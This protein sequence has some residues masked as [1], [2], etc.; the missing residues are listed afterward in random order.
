MVR[1]LR[2]SGTSRCIALPSSGNCPA[3]KSSKSCRST[4]TGSSGGGSP[5][6]F[7]AARGSMSARPAIS[8]SWMGRSN[9]GKKLAM[10]PNELAKSNPLLDFSVLPRFSEIAPEHVAP[11]I[12]ALIGEARATIEQVASVAA[13]PTWESFVQP[14]A[15]VEDRLERAWGQVS[16][17]NAVVNTPSLR[18][19]Y[20]AALPKV[21]A[22]HNELAQDE[23]LFSGYHALARVPEAAAFDGGQRKLID[24][25]LRDFR[26]S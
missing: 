1:R 7:I 9:E 18:E 17:L 23:R 24:N 25:A 5:A 20:N 14:L 26:L 13:D 8:P 12:D 3:G 4:L 10:T 2:P 11:A 22:F 6:S 16:H 21:T 19:A 15:D